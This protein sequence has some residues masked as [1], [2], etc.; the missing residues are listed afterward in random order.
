MGGED[1]AENLAESLA[2]KNLAENG[3]LGKGMWE[4]NVGGEMVCGR[5]KSCG[6]S[7]SYCGK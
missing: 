1:L 7:F 3:H 2:G 4:G 6:K 5:G